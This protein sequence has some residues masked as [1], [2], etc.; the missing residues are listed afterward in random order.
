MI[1]APIILAVSSLAFL[2]AGVG[3][4]LRPL[5]AEAEFHRRQTPH[6]EDVSARH[7]RY[8]AQLR[9]ALTDQDRSFIDRRLSSSSAAR[10]RM[11]RKAALRRYLAGIAQ[12]FAAVD[13]LAREVASLSPSVEHRH[14]SE[15]FYLEFRFRILYRLALLRLSTGASLPFQAVASLTEIVGT[16]SRQVEAMMTP[17]RTLAP[18]EPT[19]HPSHS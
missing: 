2:L 8:L 10:L 15:R 16:L 6:I 7:F 14:E 11:E 13:R 4:L 12:D 18:D 1:S 17:L 5:K 9:N 19:R 3:M